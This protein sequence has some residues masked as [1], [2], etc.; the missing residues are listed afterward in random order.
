MRWH[1][2]A[3]YPGVKVRRFGRRME[4]DSSNASGMR[5]RYTM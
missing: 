3:M 5:S 2:L 1:V 4:S